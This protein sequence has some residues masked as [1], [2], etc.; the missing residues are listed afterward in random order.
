[1]REEIEMQDNNYSNFM[2]L[3][4]SA[5]GGVFASVCLTLFLFYK[6]M[7]R[8]NQ[9]DNRLN[10]LDAPSGVPGGQFTMTPPS[11]RPFLRVRDPVIDDKGE[12]S[13]E[14]LEL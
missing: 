12:V 10:L 4:Y 3:A 7:S 6:M 5:I 13:M 1:M 2:I 11:M 8:I 14:T 9:L